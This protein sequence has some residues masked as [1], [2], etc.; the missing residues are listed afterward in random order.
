MADVLVA[1][2][3]E[4]IYGEGDT[5]TRALESV[6]FRVTEGEFAS[7]VGQSGSGK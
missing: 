2:S 6:S 4:K 3:V 5:A 1:E 7:I